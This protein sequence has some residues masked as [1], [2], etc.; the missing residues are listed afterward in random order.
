MADKSSDPGTHKLDHVSPHPLETAELISLAGET[1]ARPLIQ[2][3]KEIDILR[4]CI[5]YPGCFVSLN[6]SKQPT[7]IR[8]SEINIRPGEPEAQPVAR[9]LRNLGALVQ[10]TIEGNLNEVEP[11]VRTDQLAL[12]CGSPPQ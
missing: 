10:A 1:I 9:R 6:A 7:K 5:L 3:M 11:E 8:V 2:K 4:P 12:C